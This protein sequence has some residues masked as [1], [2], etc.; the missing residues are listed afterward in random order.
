MRWLR[1]L[2]PQLPG[3]VWLLQLGGVMNSFGNGLVLPF[4]VIYLHDVRGFGLGVS[5][6]VV[7][8]SA[9]A[10]L[11]A[12]LVAGPLVDRL[13]PRRVLGAGLV[14][15]GVGFGLFPLVRSPWQAF[16]LIAIEGAGSAGFW[17]SQSTLIARLTPP[18]R[19]HAAYAQQRVTMNLGIGLGGLAGGLI[20][21]VAHPSS[22]TLLFLIDAVTFLAYVGVLAFVHDPGVAEEERSETPAS[23][24]AV[25]RDRLFVR[26]W[27]LNFLFVTAGYSLF[28]LVPP[29]A[30]DHA[31]LSEKQIGVVFFVN[32]GLIVL[33]Q[34]PISR[35]IEG[36]RRLRALALMPLL[37]I[38]SWVL[39]DAGGYWLTGT[40]A[41]LVITVALG[42]FGVGECFHGP[43]H[44]ALVAEIAPDHLR[45]HYFAVHSLSWGLAGTVG[46]AVGGFLLASAPFALWPA[47]AVVCLIAALASLRSEPMVPE[48]FRRIPRTEPAPPVLDVAAA[49]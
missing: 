45:G 12:G 26:L 14:L 28:N 31:H 11:T 15:Q 18:P 42:I 34:L 1:S 19:R 39:V 3:G 17:P 49:G 36:H 37:W 10:Q 44:Q 43:A 30:R 24:R 40:A 41:F 22:F 46:P 32:T 2:D 33:V 47:A 7:A 27:A 20:A 29:F 5:G 25:L 16:V 23:Y 4:L 38:V 21:S 9:T 35:M 8:V 6:L 13:G 48:R